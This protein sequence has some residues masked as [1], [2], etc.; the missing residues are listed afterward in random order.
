MTVHR[1]G[2]LKAAGAGCAIA[3]APRALWPAVAQSRAPADYTL[4][5]ATGL[6]ELAPE[7]IVSTTLY[8]GQFP[9]PLG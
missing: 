5:I 6:V 2:F 3:A 9:G 8:N 1:R 4:R 7:H